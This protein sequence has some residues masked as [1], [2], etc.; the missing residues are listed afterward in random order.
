[1]QCDIIAKKNTFSDKF[2]IG[3]VFVSENQNENKVN[4]SEEKS[5]KKTELRSEVLKSIAAVVCAALVGNTFSNA[6][7]QVS[8]AKLSAADANTGD[9]SGDYSDVYEEFQSAKAEMNDSEFSDSS[10]EFTES[11]SMDTDVS[12]AESTDG[13]SGGAVS[14]DKGTDSKSTDKKTETKYSGPLLANNVV[15]FDFSKADPD[16]SKWTM[17]EIVDCYKSGMTK[18]DH[19]GVQTDQ[20]FQLIGDL[21]GAT[22]ALKEPINLAMR[23]GAQPYGALT[24]GY[25]D[26]QPSDLQKADARKEGDYVIINLYPKVQY[27][28]PNGDQHKGTVGHVCNVVEG[29]DDFIAYVEENFAVLN[30]YY[31]DDSVILKYTNAY[32][33]DVKINTKTGKMESGTWGYD[34]DVYLDHCGLL[35][36]KFNDF[37][38]TIRWKCWYPVVD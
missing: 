8:E 22:A 38:T 32:A 36:I 17:Q 16:P 4:N 25:W 21:P 29:I 20:S 6:V 35:N 13:E 33:K 34:V 3:G 14:A 18:E 30:A 31:D 19:N 9:H 28:G 2:Y 27:D 7:E 1:M 24:G 37:H 15:P 26:L 5:Q 11:E 12:S 23:L 10:D